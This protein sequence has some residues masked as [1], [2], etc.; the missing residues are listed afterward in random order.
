MNWI[1]IKDK[2]PEPYEKVLVTDGLDIQ[3]ATYVDH[4][5]IEWDM[6]FGEVCEKRITH[7]CKIKLP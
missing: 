7:W 2:M 5:K 1:S 4:H 3:Q 6:D